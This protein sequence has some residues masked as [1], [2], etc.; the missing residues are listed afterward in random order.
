[1][2][3]VA[4]ETDN[5]AWWLE[6]L[7]DISVEL[8]VIVSLCVEKRFFCRLS[9]FMDSVWLRYMSVRLQHMRVRENS[10]YGRTFVFVENLK[11]N[12]PPACQRAKTNIRPLSNTVFFQSDGLK[13]NIVE[14]GVKQQSDKQTIK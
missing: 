5:Y 6:W 4:M 9:D 13:G 7:L 12:R 14:L 3:D 10:P 2:C 1:M 8:P 11:Q